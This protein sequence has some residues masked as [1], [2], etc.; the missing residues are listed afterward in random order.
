MLAVAFGVGEELAWAGE[1]ACGQG[2]RMLRNLLLLQGL[3]QDA[4]HATHVDEVNLQ[5]PAAGGVQ[6]LGSV[7]LAKAQ[8]LVALSDSRPEQ[9]AAEEAVGELGYCGALFGGAALDAVG[10]PQG[11][12]AQLGGVVGGVGGA[13]PRGWRGWTLIN[14]PRWKMRTSLMPRPT[15]TC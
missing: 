13:A 14:W 2:W 8:E 11:V 6:A 3:E 9:R 7:A 5:G 15:S 4:F 12:G 1:A 10:R